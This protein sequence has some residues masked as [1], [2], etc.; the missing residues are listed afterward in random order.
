MSSDDTTA[1]ESIINELYERYLKTTKDSEHLIAYIKNNYESEVIP[2]IISMMET[3][4]LLGVFCEKNNFSIKLVIRLGEITEIKPQYN[5]IIER[6][7][8]LKEGKIST[9]T[10][11]IDP[12]FKLIKHKYTSL[13]QNC[14]WSYKGRDHIDVLLK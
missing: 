8:K 12:I 9:P 11:A 6:T 13:P 10:R 3:H 4:I 2:K 7:F 5:A 1:Y 14:E